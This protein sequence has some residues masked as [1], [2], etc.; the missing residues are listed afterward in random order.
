MLAFGR[1]LDVQQVTNGQRSDDPHQVLSAEQVGGYLGKYATKSAGDDP[2]RANNPHQTR[3]KSTTRQL[4]ARA[5]LNPD[6]EIRD[7]YR[8]LGQRINNTA[9]ADT[10]APNPN[11]SPSPWVPSRRAQ[12]RAARLIAQANREHRT[13]DLAAMEDALLA[14]EAK[15]TITLGHWRYAGTGWATNAETTL[16][17]ACAARAREH[18]REPAAARH[19]TNHPRKEI[20]P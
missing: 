20:H 4:A 14:D 10:S 5:A 19:A 18:E 1:Q 9:T 3:L 7:C 2:A 13:I 15:T 16:A 12:L 11:A 6:P 8:L 17:T